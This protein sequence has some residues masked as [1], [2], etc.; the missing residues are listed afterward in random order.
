MCS[1]IM[2]RVVGMASV[3]REDQQKAYLYALGKVRAGGAVAKQEEEEESEQ[4]SGKGVVAA[5][6]VVKREEEE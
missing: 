6:V 2:Q 5:G 1:I 4:G 3:S